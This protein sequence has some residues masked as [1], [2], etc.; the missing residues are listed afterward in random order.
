MNRL[1]SIAFILLIPLMLLNNVAARA[2]P[3]ADSLLTKA[4]ST[5][6][7]LPLLIDS[8]IKNSPEIRRSRNNESYADANLR[9]SRN[10]I[11]SALSFVTSYNYG[12]NFSAVNN[13]SGTVSTN[14]FTT[15]QT[16]FYN[17]GVGIQLP[18]SYILNRKN[19]IRAGQSQLNMAAAEKDNSVMLTRQ[20]V[21]ALYQDFKLSQKLMVINGKNRQAAQVNNTMA[22][23]DFLN[24]QISVDQ[25]SGVLA[26][27][28]KSIV[29][30]ETAV[31]RFQ[32]AFMQL[33]VFTGVNLSS[34]IMQV[35]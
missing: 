27:Y 8:A 21:I 5:D 30:Y 34:L 25:V 17:V 19:V 12:T 31:N 11:F 7:L 4:L 20:Q 16:G 10:A 9:I 13:P 3:A 28:N 15:A 2:Q 22:E 26:N 6:E 35:K 24:G 33:E 29:E 23:K 1:T 32:T 14:N 18:V